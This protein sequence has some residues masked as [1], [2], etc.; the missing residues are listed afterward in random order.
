MSCPIFFFCQEIDI[1]SKLCP[2]NF[3]VSNLINYLKIPMNCIP[4]SGEIRNLLKLSTVK[5]FF[6]VSLFCFYEKLVN[7]NEWDKP[8]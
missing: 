5:A 8:D 6:A 1:V 7:P 2:D 3:S 4:S